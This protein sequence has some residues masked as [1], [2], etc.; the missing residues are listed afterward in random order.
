V[1]LFC[2]PLWSEERQCCASAEDGDFLGSKPDW[3]GVKTEYD[4]GLDSGDETISNPMYGHSQGRYG[5]RKPL[6]NL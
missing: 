1:L 3:K 6:G 4:Q 2:D 5:R